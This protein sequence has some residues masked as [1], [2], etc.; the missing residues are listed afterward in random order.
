MQTRWNGKHNGK[1]NKNALRMLET[2]R[3]LCWEEESRSRSRLDCVLG[4]GCP[5]LCGPRC[6]LRYACALLKLFCPRTPTSDPVPSSIASG[7]LR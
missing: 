4:I 2:Y 3:H 7:P 1:Q 6:S 5:T